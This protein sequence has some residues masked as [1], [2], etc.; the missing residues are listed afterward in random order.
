MSRS[1]DTVI[2]DD[3]ETCPLCIEEFDLS[4]KNF[5]PCP[6][7]YQ[8]CQFCF[9]SLKTTYEKSTCP[10]CRRPYDEKT[11]QYKIPTAEEFKLD[12]LNKNKKQAAAKRKE[13]EKRE[14][15]NSSRRNLAGVRV[16]QQNLVYVIG[17]I[18]SIKDEQALLQ[19]LRGPDYFGQYGE[20]E[21]IVVSKAKPGGANQGIGV[22]V[23]YARKEDAA[24]C[25]NTV[26]GSLNGDRV[27][28]AQFGTT[29]YCSA[30]LRGETCNNKNCSFL[31]ETGEDGQHSS[32]QNE[33]HAVKPKANPIISQPAQMVPPTRPL[34]AAQNHTTTQPMARQGSK[35]D[36]SS[37]KNST[38]GSALPSTASWANANAPI[39]RTRRTSQANSRATPSPQ[40]AHASLAGPKVDESTPKE[41]P[42]TQP[43]SETTTKKPTPKPETPIS[44][45][46]PKPVDHI[47]QQYDAVLRSV[48]PHFR[49]VYDDSCLS[50]EVRASID[51][52][53]PLIDRYGGLKRR[54]MR[55]KDAAERARLEAQATSTA[56]E[57]LE[58]DNMAAGSLA[59]GGE[60]E[61]DPRSSSARGAIGRPSLSLDDSNTPILTPQQR[62]QLAF[63]NAEGGQ[64]PGLAQGSTANTAFEMSNFDRQGQ[65]FSQA[66]YEQINNHQR[67]G[68]RY[69]NTD[70]KAANNGNRFQGQQ[71]NFYSSGVQ[72]PPPGLPT[73]GTPPVSGG[74]MFAH[75]Q[76][77]TNPG[78]G[79]SKDAN[80]EVY[81]RNRSGTNQGADLSKREL[82]LSFQNNPLR[83]PPPLAPAP[84]VLNP[85]YGQYQGAYQDPGLVKQRKKGKKHRHANTSSSGGG[86]EHLADPSIVSSRVNQ[87]SNTGQ[88]LFGGQQVDDQD[89]PPLPIRSDTQPSALHSRVSSFQSFQS[90]GIRSSTPKIPP[91]FERSSTPKIPPGFE[92]IH[93]HPP[94]QDSPAQRVQTPLRSISTTSAAI[95]PAVPILP[96]GIRSATPK[97]KL[98]EPAKEKTEEADNEADTSLVVRKQRNEAN[99]ISLGSPKLRASR[100]KPELAKRVSPAAEETSELINKPSTPSKDT[101]V[102]GKGKA[103]QKRPEKIELPP[104]LPLSTTA[105][106]PTAS[107]PITAPE[108]SATPMLDSGLVGTPGSLSSRPATPSA[109]TPSDPS[110][111][112]VL[113]PR[114]LRLTTGTTSKVVEP[115]PTSAATEKSSA[116]PPLSAVKKGSRRPSLSSVQYSRPSTPAMSERPSHDASRASSPPPSIVGSAPD[117]GKSK[118]QQKKERKEKAKKT[119]EPEE[120]ASTSTTPAVAEVAPVIARQKKQKKRVESST[121]RSTDESPAPKQAE[122]IES[123]KAE[124]DAKQPSTKGPDKVIKSTKVEKPATPE[125]PPQKEDLTSKVEEM[126][127]SPYTLRDLYNEAGKTATN[128][129]SSSAIQK[130]LSEHISPMTKIISSMIQSGDLSK[131][132]PWLN[133]PSFHSAA[134]KLPSDSRRGQEYLDG[135]GYS[136][137]DAFGYIYLPLKE[138]QALKEGHAVSVA[139]A[140]ERKDDLL[141]RCLVTPNGWVLRHL[142]AD[143]SE[144][145]LELEERRQMYVEEFGD[146]GAMEGLGVLEQDDYANLGGGMDRLSRHGERH[147]V[148]WV[149]GDGDGEMGDDDEFDVYDGEDGEIDG[150]IGFSDDDDPEYLDEEGLDDE[151]PDNADFHDAVNMPG[152]WDAGKNDESGRVASMSGLGAHS[153]TMEMLLAGQGSQQHVMGGS[154]D[155]NAGPSQTVNNVNLRALDAD[156]LQKRVAE[157]QRESEQSRKEMEKIEKL[158]NKKSK[159]IGRWREVLA[160]G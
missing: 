131:D 140:G 116:F 59:L 101:D 124:S 32:L 60:P 139:D 134:Y 58:E 96:L 15:E 20:I 34:S 46:A 31:H 152:A 111:T 130:L 10:N 47:Q 38:D 57:I 83:S 136:A 132:H 37:R 125:P 160:K 12:Q 36:D 135:N 75:G 27:L 77:F 71:A 94:R 103:V 146:V 22:Y 113:R 84:G 90:S 107:A 117:R 86:V 93:G 13:T 1:Q 153:K 108:K 43:P 126:Q 100:S 79:I 35:D 16:K 102:K 138:K 23:T 65:Q 109:T 76:N 30:F 115:A 95:A 120:P 147:G 6:C 5:R 92:L 129:D 114:T 89:F 88:G 150:E 26:D 106:P 122:A 55:E 133:P 69:F 24:L 121:A 142:S 52:M 98:S 91:G 54:A 148:V 110:K 85:L 4:D 39:A 11:I 63:L 3:E 123:Q 159:D 112:S 50:P 62:Q 81:S 33:P 51:D 99:E 42:P 68:S 87:G 9:N 53:P 29:K 151:G 66:Q 105:I 82:L 149:V 25:I 67:H 144:K 44:K 145:V 74:G 137:N 21:K 155:S 40:L 158:W 56:E 61:D 119:T 2:D 141:K 45:P 128:G 18:P 72:G 64:A 154:A 48:S 8:I 157:K 104:G 97:T 127:T 19:T 73:A 7:G 156:T 80:A 49:F 14:V 41:S 78:F 70:T 118:N 17:L 28:R 143:E